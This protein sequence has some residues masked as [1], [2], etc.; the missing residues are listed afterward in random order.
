M[1]DIIYN[2]MIKKIMVQL[3]SVILEAFYPSKIYLFDKS[4][5][6]GTG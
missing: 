5:W 1:N 2:Y 4:G 6:V 3:E